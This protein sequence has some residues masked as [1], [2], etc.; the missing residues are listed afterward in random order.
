MSDAKG[1]KLFGVVGNPVK[2]SIS[3]RL[4]QFWYDELALNARYVALEMADTSP[5]RPPIMPTNVSSLT[6][7]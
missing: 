7:R 2:H 3:P 5:K 1:V 6:D 4:H